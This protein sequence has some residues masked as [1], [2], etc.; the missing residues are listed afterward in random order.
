MRKSR[1]FRLGWPTALQILYYVVPVYTTVYTLV[2][3]RVYTLC[4]HL[5]RRPVDHRRRLNHSGLVS[6]YIDYSVR[7]ISLNLDK[8][9]AQRETGS[10]NLL[11]L[12]GNNNTLHAS[13][14]TNRI[15]PRAQED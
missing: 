15:A 1:H 12:L 2:H 4:I 11:N 8:V 7:L 5:D 6:N 13:G 14:A 10:A 9:R 3:Y